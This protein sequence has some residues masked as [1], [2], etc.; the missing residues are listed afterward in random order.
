MQYSP[1]VLQNVLESV[2]IVDVIDAHVNLKKHG[3]NY[4]AC[5]P[6]HE[7]D[8]PSFSVNPDE[9]LFF[10]HGCGAGGNAFNFHAS[11]LKVSFPEAVRA[12]A[13]LGNV[14]LPKDELTDEQKKQFVDKSKLYSTL[15]QAQE[16]FQANLP[17]HMEVLKLLNAR[18]LNRDVIERFAL[19]AAKDEWQ[20]TINSLGGIGN[21]KALVDSGLAIFEA[22]TDS[23]KGKFYDRF[24]NAPVFPI[25]DAKGR[26]LSF[27]IR[28][29][30]NAVEGQPKQQKSAKYIN[31]PETDVFDKSKVSYG[32]YE[33]LQANDNP[34][35]IMVVEGYMDVITSHQF[36][37][38]NTVGTMGTAISEPKIKALYRY[39]DHLVFAFDGDKAGLEAS[40]R[41]LNAVLPF[42]NDSNKAS[43]VFMPAGEDPDSYIRKIGVE[44]YH[45]FLATN[46]I[47]ASEFIFQ[48]A[49]NGK[50]DLTTPEARGQAF[51]N[52]KV[53]MDLMPPS[54]TKAIMLSR[55]EQITGIKPKEYLPYSIELQE[56]ACNG[57]DLGSLEIEVKE[58][59]AKRLGA[60][61]ADVKVNWSM[62]EIGPK[63]VPI[64]PKLNGT[65]AQKE[66]GV[67]MREVGRVLNL[68]TPVAP[69][70]SLAQVLNTANSGVNDSSLMAKGLVGRYLRDSDAFDTECKL[71]AHHLEFIKAQLEAMN[72]SLNQATKDQISN[73]ATNVS[74]RAFVISSVNQYVDPLTAESLGR[75][76]QTITKISC[77]IAA[78]LN[79][80]EVGDNHDQR[81]MGVKR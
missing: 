77:D 57:V 80:N 71:A 12:I 38:T 18:G 4:F 22:K 43:F 68:E 23:T 81:I 13:K 76:I 47:P 11:H 45:Q 74:N 34:E 55:L 58:L 36:G 40:K 2:D 69:G 70:L 30:A 75:S 10:C 79:N 64:M 54:A 1:D 61:V 31:G 19:G 3:K 50:S 32:L 16:L 21:R 51:A 26:V 66:L 48:I 25:R 28:P 42:L 33:M 24:R 6:F 60:K 65:D 14:E 15:S 20:A 35:R 73:W 5:C 59:I 7:E 8:T 56:G 37:I 63:Q 52:S 49:R 46:T 53:L 39:S 17:T 27:G 72:S 44:A 67:R 62:P 29:L 41:A 78:N 9:Q